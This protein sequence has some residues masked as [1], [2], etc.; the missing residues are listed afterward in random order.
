M[1]ER[2]SDQTTLLLLE[3][4]RWSLALAAAVL[5]C[6]LLGLFLP[7]KVVFQLWPYR[8]LACELPLEV[9]IGRMP[10]PRS[11]FAVDDELGFDIAPNAPPTAHNA[12]GRPYE[13]WSN[14][15]GCFDTDEPIPFD[16]IYL[17]GDSYAWGYAPFA[18]KFGVLLERQLNVR[19]VKCGVPHTGQIH[20]H[21]KLVRTVGQI[22]HPPRIILI[23]LTPND[24]ANDF[25]HPHSTVLDGFLVDLR[26]LY[27]TGRRW[28]V[29]TASHDRLEEETRRREPDTRPRTVADLFLF[30]LRKIS[31]LASLSTV[32][33]G[34]PE[35]VRWV[36]DEGLPIYVG[37][38]WER[39]GRFWYDGNDYAAR[40]R[41]ALLELA[42]TARASGARL[43]VVLIPERGG[44]AR[45]GYFAE[46]RTFLE[47]EGIEFLDFA[48]RVQAETVEPWRLYWAWDPHLNEAGNTL[49]ARALTEGLRTNL[50]ALAEEEQRSSAQLAGWQSSGKTCSAVIGR[51][52]GCPTATAPSRG[53]GRCTS[54]AM[55]ATPSRPAGWAASAPSKP[56]NAPSRAA[57]RSPPD[58]PREQLPW[59]A[60]STWS[61]LTCQRCNRTLLWLVGGFHNGS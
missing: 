11:Y 55:P 10:V 1:P 22:G 50:G 20:Q 12:D 40:N 46:L 25:A 34:R 30:E 29:R 41:Q 57:P 48:E 24:I 23:T 16:Y 19:V 3:L 26:H 37:E 58:Q 47:A 33:L 28:V 7:E 54:C 39:D 52:C 32:L 5:L 2:R 17:G 53:W 9:P 13:V 51:R 21:A 38:L 36:P 44:A 60:G 59:A 43:L 4:R 6:E 35:A 56:S 49:L 61:L 14:Q 8:C 45:E 42:A 31:L 18:N 15:F 27:R